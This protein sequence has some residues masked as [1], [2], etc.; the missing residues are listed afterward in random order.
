[1]KIAMVSEHASPLARLGGPD[2]GGQNVHVA[3]LAAAL[4]SAGHEV[5]VHTRRDDPGQPHQVPLRPGVHVQHDPAGP[6]R[7]LARDELYPHMREFAENLHRSWLADPPDVVHAHFWMSGLAAL[8]ATQDLPIPLVQTFH[9]LGAVKRRHQGSEDTSPPARIHTE[10]L[11]ANQAD[12]VIATCSDEVFELARQGVPQ[13]RMSIVPC[14][15]DTDALHP[16]STDASQRRGH[17][18]VVLGRLVL[19]KGVDDVIRALPALPD[20]ELVI[21]GGPP[22]ADLHTDPDATRLHALAAQVGV[23][24]QVRLVGGV[25]R[26]DITPLLTDA[27]AVVCVPWYEPF[28]MVALEAMSCAVPVVAAAVGG[29]RDTVLDGTTGL[30]VPPR[31]PAALGD[32]LAGLLADSVRR[33]TMGAA[34]RHRAVTRY[35]WAKV[36]ADTARIYQRLRRTAHPHTRTDLLRAVGGAR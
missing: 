7:P 2:A 6:P 8:H 11:I 22:A 9:A 23:A 26:P 33:H 27:D 28:G 16:A 20:T 12:T 21:A 29:L 10:Q 17:R 3:E 19:R 31:D 36:A 24:D 1:M 34:G 18:L 30:H 14:G 13:Q 35:S 25:H 15:V 32:A 4:A 5:V